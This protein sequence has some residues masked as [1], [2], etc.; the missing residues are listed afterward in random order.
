[1]IQLIID[2][3]NIIKTLPKM[4]KIQLGVGLLVIAVLF[5][6]LALIKRAYRLNP[7][8]PPVVEEI[9]F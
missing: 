9:G 8:P 6:M 7:P 2:L 3:K 5:T 1:M 4:V